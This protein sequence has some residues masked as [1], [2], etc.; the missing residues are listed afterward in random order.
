MAL[1]V[2]R[3]RQAFDA[4]GTAPAR[5]VQGCK[6]GQT[7]QSWLPNNMVPLE[8]VESRWWSGPLPS[9]IHTSVGDAI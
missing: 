1:A 4:E 2:G 7:A 8:R 5:E 6:P 3:W 9:P